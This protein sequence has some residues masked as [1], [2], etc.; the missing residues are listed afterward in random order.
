[1]PA[2]MRYILLETNSRFTLALCHLLQS[3][4]YHSP[5]EKVVIPASTLTFC[6]HVINTSSLALKCGIIPAV[7]L[8]SKESSWKNL[9][10]DDD[11]DDDLRFGRWHR[12]WHLLLYFL[13][14]KLSYLL[15]L[16]YFHPYQLLCFYLQN[17]HL[18]VASF[19]SRQTDRPHYIRKIF[20][21]ERRAIHIE[22]T[23]WIHK[24]K[25]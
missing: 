21:L 4:F 19:L 1:M 10:E 8:H 17:P 13:C 18:P 2:D 12:R 9:I 24:S 5:R 7:S 23:L 3:S 11:D 16:K 6:V 20:W 14:S 25:E 15:M 22:K